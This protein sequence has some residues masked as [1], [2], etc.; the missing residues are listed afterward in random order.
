MNIKLHLIAA[1]VLL[2]LLVFLM[3]DEIV[4]ALVGLFYFAA[5][6][7][8]GRSTTA[9]RKFLRRYYREMLRLE[10]ML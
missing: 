2:P 4:F 8:V 1:A 10:R 5:L 7:Y 3:A 6:I 9:G